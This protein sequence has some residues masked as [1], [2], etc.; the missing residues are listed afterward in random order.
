[1]NIAS[2]VTELLPLDIDL[3]FGM[4]SEQKHQIVK[5][6]CQATVNMNDCEFKTLVRRAYEA[7]EKHGADNLPEQVTKNIRN[8]LK[9]SSGAM[10]IDARD[11]V[12]SFPNNWRIHVNTKT[13][14]SVI[15]DKMKEQDFEYEDLD[16]VCRLVRK[17]YYQSKSIE[18]AFAATANKAI[19]AHI[20]YGKD[21]QV[22]K[23]MFDYTK[24]HI[25]G[26]QNEKSIPLKEMF[27]IL[28]THL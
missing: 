8:Y 18:E 26:Y 22:S 10:Y 28:S 7:F 5:S 19:A 25:L 14:F 24:K 4:W 15:F 9:E 3:I 23:H 1:M 16:Y 13:Y 21:S 17:M 2:V 6:L 11:A 20:L 12:K 27:E